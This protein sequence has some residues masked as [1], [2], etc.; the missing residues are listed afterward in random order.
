MTPRTET[1]NI[2]CAFTWRETELHQN[3]SWYTRAYSGAQ[4]LIG[5]LES[6]DGPY[7]TAYICDT[8]NRPDAIEY[9]QANGFTVEMMNCGH[10]TETY[11][12]NYPR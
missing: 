9:M 7:Y 6:L 3:L 12:L 1:T 5:K 10:E 8:F 11:E 4:N 2:I